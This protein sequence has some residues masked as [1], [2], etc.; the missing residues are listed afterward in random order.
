MSVLEVESQSDLMGEGK[1][2]RG[3]AQKKIEEDA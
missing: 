3:E 2:D 1:N